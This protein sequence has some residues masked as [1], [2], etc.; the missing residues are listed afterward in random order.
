MVVYIIQVTKNNDF[1]RNS[2][3]VSQDA[4]ASYELA[5]EFILSR[6][7]KPK[8]I[9]PSQYASTEYTYRIRELN[10]FNPK[11]R[12][13]PKPDYNYQELINRMLSA[14]TEAEL[15]E[16][17]SMIDEYNMSRIFPAGDYGKLKMYYSDRLLE[18]TLPN[19][20]RKSKRG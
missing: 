14:T 16:I 15:M 4:F 18:L 2:T 9:M 17:K 5:K 12:S 11:V 10:V 6:A 20:I 13:H 7:D 8:L 1:T 3:S 19:S